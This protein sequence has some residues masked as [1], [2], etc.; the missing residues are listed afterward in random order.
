[1]KIVEYKTIGFILLKVIPKIFLLMCIIFMLAS[2]I[3]FIIWKYRKYKCFKEIEIFTF[4]ELFKDTF[5]GSLAFFLLMILWYLV[6]GIIVHFCVELSNDVRT[7]QIKL[8]DQ[9]IMNMTTKD[10][11]QVTN[12]LSASSFIFSSSVYN[13]QTEKVDNFYIVRVAYRDGSRLVKFKI[14]ESYIREYGI[15]MEE[16]RLFKWE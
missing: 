3:F 14:D 8:Y 12:N 13:S 7:T 5:R 16:V 2:I 1:M 15:D 4:K 9:D 6:L 10:E 11:T